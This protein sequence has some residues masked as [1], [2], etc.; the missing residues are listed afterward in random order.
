[1]IRPL[2]QATAKLLA[3]V[4]VHPFERLYVDLD[5]DGTRYVCG[6]HKV[7]LGVERCGIYD[8]VSVM[9]FIARMPERRQSPKP[10]DYVWTFGGTDICSAIL[11]AWPQEQI[12]FTPEAKALRDYWRATV[13]MQNLNADD[14]AKWKFAKIVPEHSLELHANSE[15]AL[16][17][18]QI[19]AAH[20]AVRSEGFAFFMEPGTGKTPTSVA[21]MCNVAKRIITEAQRPMRVII[22]AP[23][24]VRMNWEKEIARFQTRDCLVKVLRGLELNRR[25]QL[26]ELVCERDKESLIVICSYDVVSRS[27]DTIGS[28][29]WDLAIADESH[30]FK[31][32]KTNRCEYMHALRDKARK[33]LI[34]TGTEITNSLIDLW[35]QLEFLGKGYSG[36]MGVKTFKDF[37]GV[38]IKD[39]DGN[40]KLIGSQNVPFLQE[41]LARLSF[42]ITT[43]QALPFLPPKS[44]TV[45][46]IELTPR[47]KD[48]YKQLRDKL[49]VE[50]EAD[51]KDAT[52]RGMPKQLIVA[53]GFAKMLRLAEITSGYVKWSETLDDLGNV[54]RPASIELFDVNPKL[55]QLIMDLKE[56]K[57]WE[58]TIIWCCFTANIRQIA[59]RLQQEQM[60]FVEYY[61]K[62]KDKDREQSEY[63]F[64]HDEKYRILLGNPAAGGIGLNL[65]GHQAGAGPHKTHCTLEA[66][67]SQGWLPTVRWQAECRALRRG[68]EMPVEM[69]DYCVIGSV[70][71]QIRISAVEK[72][73][74]AANIS[75]LQ[76]VLQAVLTGVLE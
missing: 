69:R 34:L 31:D 10:Y 74:N 11:D 36:F 27:W 19:V 63:L 17:P 9:E 23:K 32:S 18:Y 65:W 45:T 3:P 38:Y 64:N 20:C 41:R 54:A 12:E 16:N 35:A 75:D 71:E 7:H 4:N 66:F 53:N 56:R 61:G 76:D 29:E 14:Y 52:E 15:L 44:Y 73:I 5:K 33:R 51:I 49:A 67:Y 1:M 47:Q 43:E 60:P 6:F 50:I 21:V 8:A 58:K 62:T 28:V 30:F 22:V 42:K 55:E 2:T 37:Y 40:D 46:E 70:D 57:E 68:T 25:K 48:I 26:L 13:A 24:N 59:E 72:K 39:E